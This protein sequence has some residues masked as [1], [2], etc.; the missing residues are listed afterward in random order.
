VYLPGL[1]TIPVI[2][3]D[4]AR[5]AQASRQM[6][7]SAAF[8][9]EDQKPEFHEGG[10]AVPM[11]QDRPRLNKPPL[12]YWAQVASAWI[13]T[14]GDPLKDAIWMYRIPSV[15][16]SVVAVVL[17]WWFA[18]S[19]FDP[20]AAWL[21]AVFLAVCPVVAFD[22]H[23]ARADQLLLA[24]IVATQGCLWR[25]WS[26]IAS[27]RRGWL[28]WVLGFWVCTGVSILA[29][30][31]IG[32]MIAAL[33]VV[34]IS[35]VRS[36]WRWIWKLQPHLGVVIAACIVAPWVWMV[37]NHVGWEKY[38]AIIFDETI[39]R[40]MEG[41][42]G[43]WGPPGYHTALSAVL[44]WPGSMM[45]G[46][47]VIRAW[48]KGFGT[49]VNTPVDG[50]RERVGEM[51]MNG[52]K[53]RDAE[54]F[55]IAWIIPAWIVFELVGTK[56]PHYTLPMY[57]A[58]LLLSARMLLRAASGV[59]DE[60]SKVDRFGFVAWWVIGFVIAGGLIGAI[61]IT[62]LHDTSSTQ[63][64]LVGGI[65][66]ATMALT[67][68]AIVRARPRIRLAW[69]RAVD[70]SLQRQIVMVL[71]A[72]ACL[73]TFFAVLAPR[74]LPGHVTPE[75]AR[76]I[77]AARSELKGTSDVPV[78]AYHEDSLIFAM[79]GGVLRMNPEEIPAWLDGATGRIAVVRVDQGEFYTL[80]D[81]MRL[82]IRAPYREWRR[83]D[84]KVGRIVV[85][86]WGVV[87]RMQD[88][89]GVE[90]TQ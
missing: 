24:T 83:I 2:D 89:G 10:W 30:G 52:R 85:R 68:I 33:T 51:F 54:L 80:E 12:I 86:S 72:I 8:R 81:S 47:G 18:R 35:V 45:A 61:T 34:G 19:M 48:R 28:A 77:A 74:L 42:E 25:A 22:A 36:N 71:V 23:Q 66:L 43:H 55:C 84:E 5:F 9:A 1:W 17:T 32:P 49:G 15:L 16:S 62:Y 76:G 60:F 69:N 14:G 70:L 38:F 87:S 6:F 88:S 79:R 67:M 37:G 7:E 53:G 44:L 13:F 73:G 39:G 58:I 63:Q 29:K 27:G 46:L 41:K 65:A 57:P 78:T 75:I 11:V 31:P 59:R 90:G 40:S 26:G 64:M 20:R 50:W 56:L 4:E 82:E 21:G 3:R